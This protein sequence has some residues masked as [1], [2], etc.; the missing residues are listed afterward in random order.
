MIKKKVERFYRT[1]TFVK[2][3]LYIDYFYQN[4]SRGWYICK[5]KERLEHFFSYNDA[6]RGLMRMKKYSAPVRT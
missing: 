1:N 4:G 2:D 5:N 3:E 6:K